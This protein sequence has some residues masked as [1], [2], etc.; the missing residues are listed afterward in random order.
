[1]PRK[2]DPSRKKRRSQSAIIFGRQIGAARVLL[3]L[4][5]T[6][7]A[8]L[9]G[10]EGTY[11]SKIENAMINPRLET[12]ERI[13]RVLEAQGIIFTNGDEPGVK[14]SRERAASANPLGTT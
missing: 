8:G 1:M 6:E 11:L 7:L 4:N 14:T 10:I 2:A 5:Q 12:R 3:G 13:K 9:L